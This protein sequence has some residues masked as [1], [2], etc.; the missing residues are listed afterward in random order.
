MAKTEHPNIIKYFASNWIKRKQLLWITM[1]LCDGSL[2][3]FIENL[4]QKTALDYFY[5]ICEGVRALHQEYK[6]IHR[7]LKPGNILLKNNIPK[8][9]DFGE[10]KTMTKTT[11]TLSDQKEAFGTYEYLAPEIFEIME[12]DD[13][14]KYNEKT[15]IWALGIIFHKMLAKNMHPFLNGVHLTKVNKI[16]KI[17]KILHENDPNIDPTIIDPLH[18]KIL[19]GCLQKSPNDRLDIEEL[20]EIFGKPKINEKKEP[21][22]GSLSPMLDDTNDNVEIP[23]FDSKR[24]KIIKIIGAG[25][26]AKV[27]SAMDSLTNT[28]VALKESKMEYGN[29]ELNLKHEDLILRMIN[30]IPCNNFL[31]YYGLYKT[32]DSYIMILEKGDNDLKQILNSRKIFEE[33]EILYLFRSLASNLLLLNQYNICKGEIKPGDIIMTSSIVNNKVA[34]KFHIIDFG[35]SYILNNHNI[36]SKK[37]MGFTSGFAA[38]E[39]MN[40]NL[41]ENDF[42]F[43]PIKAEIYSLGVTIMNVSGSKNPKEFCSKFTEKNNKLFSLLNKMVDANPEKRPDYKRILEELGNFDIPESINLN[44]N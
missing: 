28:V 22:F 20:L 10:A 43:D 15:D 4:D 40:Y 44:R 33:K 9:C 23:I 5:Q 11:M 8:L 2:D 27:S 31:K 6:I 37:I 18:I 7:D 17:R 14:P 3:Q 34:N 13:D 1:E 16:S 26:F 32:S 36:S 42:D 19:K 25:G 24:Y 39:I 21:I 38:P 29:E 30:M 35:V 12:K 41:E